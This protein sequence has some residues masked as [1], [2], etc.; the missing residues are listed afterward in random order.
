MRWTCLWTFDWH[1]KRSDW[2][3][4]KNRCFDWNRTWGCLIWNIHTTLQTTGWDAREG[5]KESRRINERY[6]ILNVDGSN[7][8]T[9]PNNL[10]SWES[11]IKII[12]VG[13]DKA[14]V[15]KAFWCLDCVVVFR[16]VWDRR[17]WNNSWFNFWGSKQGVVILWQHLEMFKIL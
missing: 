9:W 14:G 17:L 3:A 6:P 10:L 11:K 7:K 1:H 8:P 2:A 15:P 12:N 13:D 5:R 4:L 16:L